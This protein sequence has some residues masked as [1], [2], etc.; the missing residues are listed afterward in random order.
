MAGI[1]RGSHARRRGTPIGAGLRANVAWTDENSGYGIGLDIELLDEYG[2]VA[3]I[4]HCE[5][6]FIED[7]ASLLDSYP[8]ELEGVHACVRTG[9]VE[10]P[11]QQEKLARVTALREALRRLE[12]GEYPFERFRGVPNE[13]DLNNYKD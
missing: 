9:T 11:E 13:I 4:L 6:R 10:V 8:D 1:K 12:A 3:E 2:H 5:V 7:T